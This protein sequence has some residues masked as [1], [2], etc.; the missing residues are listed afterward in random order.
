M[1]DER[2]Q[3]LLVVRAREATNESLRGGSRR[4]Q[5]PPKGSTKMEVLETLSGMA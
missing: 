4:L 1:L 2:V 3:S 5:T